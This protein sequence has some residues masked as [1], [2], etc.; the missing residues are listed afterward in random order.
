MA[1]AGNEPDVPSG[2]GV[3]DEPPAPRRRGVPNI[4]HTAAVKE[5][6][7]QV[8]DR[9]D[10]TAAGQVRRRVRDL[11]VLNHGVILAS[12]GLT[13]LIPALITI[14]AVLPVGSKTGL[15]ATV[16]RR[17]GLSAQAADD[18]RK[19]FPTRDQ[20]AGTTT[21]L[22]AVATLFWAL[23]WPTELARGYQS[24]WELPSRGLR[25]MWR[26]V[27]WL[28]SFMALIAAIILSS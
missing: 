10:A 22:S 24:I 9:V 27:P 3:A 26:S 28:L 17:F 20:V 21:V 11:D 4:P 8:R 13:L 25:D 2:E 18:L 12:L 14:S 6:Y 16:I 5:R 19:V 15:A 7:V 23:G 1:G